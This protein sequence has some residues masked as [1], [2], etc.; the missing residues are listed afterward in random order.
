MFVEEKDQ[1]N[2]PEESRDGE[3]Q[4]LIPIEHSLSVSIGHPVAFNRN[5]PKV[6]KNDHG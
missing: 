2:W 5:E 6:D 3:I 1:S 4:E